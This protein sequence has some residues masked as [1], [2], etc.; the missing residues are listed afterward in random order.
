MDQAGP[1][2]WKLLIGLALALLGLRLAWASRPWVWAI[3]RPLCSP[4]ARKESA[5]RRDLERR[6][7]EAVPDSRVRHFSSLDPPRSSLVYLV[8]TRTDRDRD[9]LSKDA[10]L[11]ASFRRML[12]TRRVAMPS[13]KGAVLSFQSQE[14]V[15]RDYEGSWYFALK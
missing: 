15:D 3:L 6:V 7:R 10:E 11:Q 12:E 1:F 4:T 14:T 2:D 5:V 13:A 9:L 8:I